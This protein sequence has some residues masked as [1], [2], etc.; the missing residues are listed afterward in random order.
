MFKTLLVPLDGSPRA[1]QA[2]PVALD[3]A[4]KYQARIVL[5]QVCT[6]PVTLSHYYDPGPHEEQLKQS[7]QISEQYLTELAAQISQQGVGVDHDCVRDQPAQAIL[8]RASHLEEPLIVM[9]SHGRDGLLRWLL[10]S[11][12][13]KIVRHAECPVMIVRNRQPAEEGA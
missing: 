5:L 9:T 13:E 6:N 10:G 7:E 2:I 11:T 8:T 3:L 4:Q 1:E 12:A